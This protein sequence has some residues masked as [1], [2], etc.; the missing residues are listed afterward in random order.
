MNGILIVNKPKDFTSR[1]V[2]NKIGGILKTKKI[3]HTGTLDPI[4]TGVLVICIG[5]TT[6]LCE[7]LTSEYKEYIATIKLGIKTD[8]LDTTGTIIETKEFNVSEQQIKEVLSSFLGQSTQITPIYSAVKVN[9]KKLYEYAREGIEVELPKREINI[10]NIELISFN[11]DEIVFKTTVSK[12]TYIRALIDDICKKINTV[13]TMSSLIRTKQG[14]FNIDESYTIED[15]EKGNYKLIPIE[16]ALST[17]ESITI[18]EETYNKVKNGSI[19][20]KTFK[21][22]IANLIYENKIVAIYQTYHSDNNKAK[23]FKMFIN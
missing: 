16:E 17:L 11:N 2:V 22:D 7:V 9:G 10:N 8:T 14:N 15:I 20:D 21:N 13:G 18:D 5:N 23:P 1:D 19:I 12:G 6:K 3:G 4:A